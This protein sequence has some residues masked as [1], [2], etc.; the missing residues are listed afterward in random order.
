MI[1]KIILGFILI[2]ITWYIVYKL[3]SNTRHV[4]VY[5]YWQ[6]ELIWVRKALAI[7]VTLIILYALSQ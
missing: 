3:N 2:P 1:P 5:Y 4:P 7:V 6:N